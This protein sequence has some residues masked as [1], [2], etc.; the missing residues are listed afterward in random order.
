MRKSSHGLSWLLWHKIS[1]SEIL[2]HSTLY[3][4]W[5][6]KPFR[7]LYI[8]KCRLKRHNFQF[9]FAF[10]KEVCLNE[11]GPRFHSHATG[12]VRDTLRGRFSQFL[13]IT[14]NYALSSGFHSIRIF[15]TNNN[16]LFI[17]FLAERKRDKSNAATLLNDDSI[18]FCL[19]LFFISSKHVYIF[20]Y[21]FY[22]CFVFVSQP[23]NVS[24]VKNVN[25]MADRE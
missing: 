19:F 20:V 2:E 22:F 5:T 17:W 24:Y 10:F 18:L 9:I 21:Y 7:I 14:S 8:C 15:K 23:K 3:T 11:S 4:P 6:Y 16:K 1:H 25:A 13:C 12:T